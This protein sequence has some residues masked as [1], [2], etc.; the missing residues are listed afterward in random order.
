[1]KAALTVL[2]LLPLVF[3]LAIAGDGVLNKKPIPFDGT[4]IVEGSSQLPSGPPTI[5][6]SPGEIIGTSYYAYQTNGSTGNRISIDSEGGIH[7]SYT[8]GTAEGGRPRYVYYNFKDETTGDWLGETAISGDNG[9]GFVTMDLLAGGEAMPCYHFADADVPYTGIAIDLFR[10]FGIFEEIPIPNRNTEWIWPYVARNNT[11]EII[12]VLCSDFNSEPTNYGYTFSTNGGESWGEYQTIFATDVLSGI[13]C[14]SPV[15]SKTAIV[16]TQANEYNWYD[17]LLFESEDGLTWDWS[18]P[19]NITESGSSPEMEAFADVDG[20]YDYNDNLHLSYQGQTVDLDEGVSYIWG[21][22]MHWSEATGPTVVYTHPNS[23]TCSTVNY[24]SCMSKMSLGVNPENGNLFALW[25]DLSQNDVSAAGYSNGELFAAASVDNGATW[26]PHVNLTNSH[27]PG[28]ATGD[29]DS[30]IYSSLAE[31]VD[32][33]LHIMY[34]D[35]DD[36]GAEWN[37]EGGW[38]NNNVLYLTIEEGEL[39]P[40]SVDHDINT[41]FEF[42]LSQNYPNPFNAKTVI[43]VD[44]DFESGRLAIYDI[45]GRLVNNFA[46]GENNRTITWDG[47]DLAGDVVASGTYFY[48]VNVDGFGTASVK[49]MT[50]LK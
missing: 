37:G 9:T 19:R 8:K 7:I 17:V 45:A 20:L 36:A 15:S 48:S 50:L 40:L 35:D 2:L 21:N 32:G 47:T 23:D 16:W 6:D 26:L 30:D 14:T 43:N 27:T 5:S 24:C 18:N 1:M 11:D 25:A 22:I 46:I 13:I 3:G 29:C 38:T 4:N 39:I 34:V 12:H 41:P 44:G 10:G 28:C 42:E 49:K 31:V 33:N